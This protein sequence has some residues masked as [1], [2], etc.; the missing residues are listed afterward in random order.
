MNKKKIYYKDTNPNENH[1]QVKTNQFTTNPDLKHRIFVMD[2]FYTNPEELR[3]FAV[4]QWYFDDEGFEG[5]RTRKQFFFEG[6]KEKFESTIGKKITKWEEHGMN[7]RFQNHKADF[8]P[9]YHCDS[10]TWAAA[11]YLNPNA[12][13]EAGTAFYAHKNTGLRGGEEEIGYAFNNK[14]WV[15]STPYTKVDEVGN[16]YN[17]CVIWDAKL[18]HAAPVY[19]GWDVDTARLTQVFFFDAE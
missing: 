7:A 15:D 9:V 12:P 6:V 2:N 16:I 13:Y 17:R 3:Q 10:Q 1:G 19:F 8:R 5:L 18:I 11:V 14:T 4:Q